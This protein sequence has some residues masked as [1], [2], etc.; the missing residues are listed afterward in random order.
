MIPVQGDLPFFPPLDVAHMIA[1]ACERPQEKGLPLSRYSASDIARLVV[2]LGL[3]L[4]ISVS[5]VRRILRQAAIKPWLVRSW[6]FPRDPEFRE[7]ASRVLDLYER[8]W[9]GEPLGP[10]DYVICADEKTCIQALGRRHEVVPPSANHAILV[11]SEYKRAGTV[12]YLAALD[13]KSGRIF[14][15]V[16][17]KTGITPFDEFVALV[18]QQEPYCSAERVFWVVDNGCSH[19]PTTFPDR[20]AARFPNAIAV[21]LP[22]HASWLNPAEVY[23][24]IVQ[25]KALTPNDL[26]STY[27]VKQRL[28]G[29]QER[30]NRTAKAFKWR[31]T[32]AEL[33][34]RLAEAA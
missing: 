1:L 11:D 18:M 3:V 12:A 6:I 13:V 4:E 31:F 34:K 10:K 8:L 5:T 23:F 17:D 2:A 24:S 7:K 16:I 28:V 19:Q 27:A 21:H 20:L 14:G 30:Y 25:R 33:L 22:I 32:K 9:G 26:D 15:Q 29:Y